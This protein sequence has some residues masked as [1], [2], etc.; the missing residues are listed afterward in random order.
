[1]KKHLINHLLCALAILFAMPSLVSAQQMPAIPVDPNVRIGKLDNGLTYYIRHNEYPKGQAD[2]YIAQKVGS[3]QEDDNQRGLA[4]FL[5][6]MAFNGSKH[7]PD[8]S[9]VHWLE[10]VG[11]KFGRN[12]NAGTG[13]DQTTYYF[14]Q[15]PTARE[16]VQD[17]CLLVLADWADGL[18]LE[19]AEIDK[20]RG[21][22]HEEWRMRNVG[23]QRLM[24]EA[25]PIIYPGSKY[26]DRMIIGTM[27]IVDNFPYQ[28]LRDYYEKW[29]RPDLQGIVI[30][31]DIDVDR[32]E[33]K[34]KEIFSPIKMPANPAKREYYE[35]PDNEET[36][37]YVGKD[38][39]LPNAMVRLMFKSDT[40]PDSMKGTLDYMVENYAVG[41]MMSMLRNRLDEMSTK[42]DA[43]FAAASASNGNYIYAKTKDAFTLVA[44]PKGN[45]VMPAFESIYRE[46]LRAK[47]GGFTASEYDRARSEY[48]SRLENQY[49]NR[50]TIT[51]TALAEEYVANFHDNEPIPGIEIEYQIMSMLSQQLNVDM[52]NAA[53]A[54]MMPDN[55]TVVM[56]MLPDNGE[57]KIPTN[58]ELAEAM[59]RVAAEDIE[60]F[61][62]E[63]KAEPLIPQLPAPGTIVSTTKDEHWD[64]TVWKLSNGATVVVKPTTYKDNEILFRAYAPG[65]TST[66]SSDY[67]DLLRVF[68]YVVSTNGLGD[69]TASDLNKYLAGKQAGVS[70]GFD[71]Y[72]RSLSGSAVP[73]DLPTL[74]ELIY[75]TFKDVTITQDEFDATKN[76]YAGFLQ[77]Q[78]AEPS[79]QFSKKLMEYM[80]ASP[81]RHLGGVDLIKNADRQQTVDL[82]HKEL[83]NPGE[84][85]FFFVGNVD[86]ETLKPLVEQYIASL[87][88]SAVNA[89][90]IKPDPALALRAGSGTEQVTYPM[91]TPQTW[92]AILA[93]ANMPYS[94]K[95]SK[96]ASVAG[97]IL[98]ARL[99]K[100]VREEKGAVYSISA[101]GSMTRE[102]SLRNVVMQTAFPMKPEMKDEVLEIIA[103]QFDDMTRNISQEELDKVKEFMVKEATANLEK[104]S[105]WASAM[106]AYQIKPVDGF[107]GAV[108]EINSI[109]TDDVKK[110][111]KELMDQN[112]YQVF[113]MDPAEK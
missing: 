101:S 76:A 110:F 92:V 1:M 95:Y 40:R 94:T 54:E 56:V 84:F 13:F 88:G 18:L 4:H 93:T 70:F 102:P 26:A 44:I 69:Y 113:V 30:V 104:N 79:Y 27:E 23:Q 99:V 55:N 91:D 7:F 8:N 41:M 65:G 45:D 16:S 58:E 61:V 57:Y 14:T 31:G 11:V 47:R 37:Y 48:L 67:D 77:N 64:A 78:E 46:A 71:D 86:P 10:T 42:P 43:P 98:T 103:G 75:M 97:Q 15:V 20:E 87:P 25:L 59:K 63:V 74:M 80:Y 19:D 109:T 111:M 34:I 5:E 53:M 60:V 106:L 100:L 39:E 29:Y 33:N 81:R 21:V 96:L 112:N 2:Y 83:A 108:E 51:N 12:L 9:L 73:K 17:S 32:I 85:T 52:L 72:D 35:V 107:T 38:K 68:S 82:I 24:E 90:E 22:I 3:I 66:L 49:K 50:N 28:D 36:I 6:H 62:D 105:A 89:A